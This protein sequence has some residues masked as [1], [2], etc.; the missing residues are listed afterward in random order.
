MQV[1][2]GLIGLGRLAE[3]HLAGAFAASHTGRLVACAGRTG[4]RAKGFAAT[5]GVESTHDSYEG[6]VRD[7][8]VDAVYVATPNHLHH[9]VVLAAA[10]GGKH[11][12]CE[13]PMGLTPREAEEMVEACRRA[14]VVL[15]VG[16]Q[17]RFQ[18]VLQAAAAAVREGRLGILREVSVQRYGPMRSSRSP[19]QMDLAT[20][21][22]GV[23]GGLGVHAIDF[24]H[25][26]VGDRIERV[27][28]LAH[29]G[30][31]TGRPE[32]S[33]TLVLEFAG[34]CQAVIRCGRGLPI[35]VNDLQVFGTRGML[36]TGPLRWGPTDRLTVK[37]VD[38]IEEREF[39]R[40]NLYLREIEAFGE[41]VAGH[42]TVGASGEDG[43]WLARVTDALI[44]SFETG[45]LVRVEA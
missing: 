34:G 42:R 12:L 33:A 10:A 24:V 32:D 14:G 26:I 43:L 36:A 30:R 21:G 20:A 28:G 40:D 38:T 8:Q 2:W 44:R 15:K 3:E 37:T 22:S 18:D 9:P 45:A 41:E 17:S 5:H 1:R 19:W 35:G 25:W 13:K 16:L 29:P 39:P 7:P 23:L 27:F 6:L 31:A 11:V 4:D